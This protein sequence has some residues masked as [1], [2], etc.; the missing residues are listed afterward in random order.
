M[1]SSKKIFGITFVPFSTVSD[2]KSTNTIVAKTDLLSIDFYHTLRR[3]DNI[4]CHFRHIAFTAAIFM[5]IYMGKYVPSRI[6]A[7]RKDVY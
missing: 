2:T 4:L 3:A 6:T 7:G 5:V 1:F